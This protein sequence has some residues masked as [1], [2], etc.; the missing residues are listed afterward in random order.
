MHELMLCVVG[1]EGVSGSPH[2]VHFAKQIEFIPKQINCVTV[3]S[4]RASK[5]KQ[6]KPCSLCSV[7]GI[8]FAY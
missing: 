2:S 8:L 3:H 7:N 5:P 6:P 4:D 1:Y